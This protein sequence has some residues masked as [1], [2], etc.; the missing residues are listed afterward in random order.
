MIEKN[1]GQRFLII[2]GVLLFACLM[3]YSYGLRPGND[4]AG[5]VSMVFEIDTAGAQPDQNLAEEMKQLLQ[6]RVDPKGVYGLEWRVMGNNRLEVQMPLPPRGVAELRNKYDD[7]IRALGDT[8]ITRGQL[9]RVL[10]LPA[11][12]R[13][14]EMAG[15]FQYDEAT[16]AFVA[17]LSEVTDEAVK[18]RLAEELGGDDPERQEKALT[19]INLPGAQGRA[20]AITDDYGVA[21]SRRVEQILE[22]L[23]RPAEERLA[24]LQRFFG[25]AAAKREQ[26][27]PKAAEASDTWLVTQAK[28]AELRAEED[29]TETVLR[30][31][32][33]ALRDA[34]EDRDDLFD[35]VMA[36]NFPLNQ[37]RDV[38]E[39]PEGAATRAQALNTWRSIEFPSLAAKIDQA[40]V[41]H[42]EWKQNATFLDGPED[43]RRLL[44]G[45]G[46][47][48][49]R[50]LVEPN[51]DNLSKYDRLREM[52]A[53][54]GPRAASTSEEGWFRIDDP[55]NFFNLRSA[56][57]VQ[58]LDPRTMQSYVAGQY[59]GEWYVLAR[60]DPGGQML[61]SS[62][63][64]WQ[65]TSAYRGVDEMGR[66]NVLFEFDARG[67]SLFGTLTGNNINKQLSVFVDDVAYSAANIQ[68]RIAGNGQ[69]T[70]QFTEDKV[71]YLVRSMNAGALPARLKDT[72]ISE[73]TLGSSLG[74]ANRDKA[75]RA[76][77]IGVLLVGIIMLC[78]Y[79]WAG[80]IANVALLMNILLVLAVMSMLSARISLAGI[81]GI[82]LTIGM[83]VDANVLI[84]E[85]IREEKKR[86]ASLRMMIKNGYDKALSTIVDANITTLLTSIIIAYV[87]S[88]EIK[89]F[90][91]TLG[92]GIVTSLFTSLFVTRTV[93]AFLIKMR[94]ISDVKMLHIIGVPKIDWYG[95][96]AYFLPISV[97][98]ITVGLGL[99]IA[100]GPDALDV[101]FRGG[102]NAEFELKN[103]T[104]A[105]GDTV[106]DIVINNR[107]DEIANALSED[108]AK[109]PNAQIEAVA[110]D[111]T[112]FY[113]RVPGVTPERLAALITEPLEDRE[114]L[115]R[116]G[117]DTDAISDGVSVRVG[118]GRTLEELEQEINAY[119]TGEAT[120]IDTLTRAKVNKVIE[121]ES[122]ELDGLV[123]S[124][125]TTVTNKRLVEY[126]LEAAMG[127]NLRR[128]AA[129][130][131]TFVG[132]DGL[133]FPITGGTLREVIPNLPAEGPVVDV[134][135]YL[136]GAAMYFTEL[137]PPVA[138]H[139]LYTRLRN[140][141]LQ[142]DYQ[143]L[144]WRQFEVLGVSPTGATDEE[145]RALYNSI[146]IVALDNEHPY[147]ESP[148]DWTAWLAEP[149]LGLARAALGTEQ[150]LRKVSTFKP[151]I[152]GQSQQKAIIALVLSWIMIVV[153]LWIRFGKP[154]YGVAGVAALIHDVLI[155]LAAVGISGFLGQTGMF[156][157]LLIHDFP[158]NMVIV[159]AFLTI[160]GYSINDTIVVFDRIRETRGRLG[161]VTPEVINHSINQCLARTI[162]T[163]ATTMVV[164]M[165]M[166]IFGGDSI[167]GFNYCMIVGI[168][169][170][171]YSSIAVAAPILMMRM[172]RADRRAARQV[173]PA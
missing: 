31:A 130:D 172:Q 46:V 27:L 124:V 155:A 104:F 168:I 94:W 134:T 69:I 26:L 151:Q 56:N 63:R 81:A 139:V 86:G 57:E 138:P 83:T 10:S 109:L 55:V 23:E 159:A 39:L 71:R 131:F 145:G 167:R 89:G 137:S 148:E 9:Q 37:F 136:D 107:I 78:Y 119:A 129:I 21:T 154:T 105:N 34:E 51:P 12:Q 53:E 43:L 140:M 97:T 38:L 113:V 173:A 61:G 90:G 13:E 17:G 84:F 85:R 62:K 103:E 41:A 111:Q 80:A 73:R 64:D 60:T 58:D 76:G 30:E 112:L 149:E 82:I 157:F 96:R 123:W 99:L 48:S 3:L 11:E 74:E 158:I 79:M 6:R 8:Q 115:A 106:N 110:G 162:M 163:S 108:A 59:A 152:A 24:A 67:G 156:G 147:S 54:R 144:P 28:L 36:T 143:D 95:K 170:G 166:Y 127:D 118:S 120:Q 22:S 165:T 92:W 35:A 101:E 50:I 70:G 1:L 135:K 49:F 19:A 25:G 2:A 44:R 15:L 16:K 160:I 141:R 169:T 122:P 153:Y 20:A 18:Q 161:H 47:L 102:V 142:P 146:A 45:A 128:Q 77:W 40:I 117:V 14:T 65:L 171:T 91:V 126:A 121:T 42:A 100:R 75:F 32:Q 132:D 88:E 5:G 114:V 4:I 164:L 68:V 116:A 29:I 33:I 7:A 87:G 150:S 98:V 133:P 93:F 72:P 52:L 125:T 66:P